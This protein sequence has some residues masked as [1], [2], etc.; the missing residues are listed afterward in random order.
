MAQCETDRVGGIGPEFTLQ[1]Q[2]GR[3]HELNLFLLR[4]TLPDDRQLHFARRVFAHGCNDRKDAADGRSPR[5]PQLQCAV[6]VAV[7]E[8][9][10]DRDLLRAVLPHEFLDAVEDLA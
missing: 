4:A 2:E 10:L 3:H 1:F 5:L 8:N 9:A 6:G 7:H